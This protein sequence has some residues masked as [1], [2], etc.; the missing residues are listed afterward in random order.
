VGGAPKYAVRYA[1]RRMRIGWTALYS[2]TMNAMTNHRQAMSSFPQLQ[3]LEAELDEATARAHRLVEGL[4][5]NGW[6]ERPAPERW[7]PG[8]QIVHLNLASRA[9][10]PLL[11]DAVARGRE[12][13]LVGE[14]PYRRDFLGWLLGRMTEPP[15]RLRVK[16]T[17]QFI[18]QAALPPPAEVMRDFDAL[19]EEVKAVLREARG[20]ALDRIKVHSPFDPRLR[21]NVYSALRL[22]PAHQRHHLWLAERGLLS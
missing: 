8:E 20:L 17:A 11:R 9:Y 13:G 2:A 10:L 6:T 15:V 3:A 18:P 14:G 21:Y 22:I 5:A 12:Q 4:G 1:D 19:Q 16:T 7:S